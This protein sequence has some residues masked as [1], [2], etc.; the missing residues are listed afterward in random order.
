MLG[1]TLL[2]CSGDNFSV[3]LTCDEHG[4]GRRCRHAHLQFADASDAAYHADR[5]G[6]ARQHRPA[7]GRAASRRSLL[8]YSTEDAAFLP[9][10]L[11]SAGALMGWTSAASPR[12]TAEPRTPPQGRCGSGDMH[13]SPCDQASFLVVHQGRH[14]GRP[15]GSSAGPVAAAAFAVSGS[16]IARATLPAPMAAPAVDPAWP[17]DGWVQ[18]APAQLDVK[19]RAR[20]MDEPR[21][22]IRRPK[23]RLPKLPGPPLDE[24]AP[25][26]SLGWGSPGAEIHPSPTSD[27]DW[28]LQEDAAGGAGG[29]RSNDGWQL[30]EAFA[31]APP[32]VL[33]GCP[34]Q[35][36]QAVAAA[37]GIVAA[38]AMQERTASS[39]PEWQRRP[40]WA[41][42]WAA[43]HALAALG[44]HASA[45]EPPAARSPCTPRA[46][47][48]PTPGCGKRPSTCSRPS[49]AMVKTAAAAALERGERGH[50]WVIATKIRTC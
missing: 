4:F 39:L 7:G 17:A 38:P 30:T 37:L 29:G 6:P 18:A 8:G 19:R 11:L 26:H 16:P 49:S 21:S 22:F 15:A 9:Q 33:A 12:G 32:R 10:P 42:E 35:A 41:S 14:Q 31:M 3:L 50:N 43:R 25:S 20:S 46:T 1:K 2:I 48:A 36:Q 34:Q 27:D 45:F 23:M 44:R 47:A 28:Q 13:S 5:F 40:T 24:V